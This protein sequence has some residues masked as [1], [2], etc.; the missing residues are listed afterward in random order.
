[1]HGMRLFR[2]AIALAI[3]LA[4]AAGSASGSELVREKFDNVSVSARPG[5]VSGRNPQGKGWTNPAAGWKVDKPVA[6]D[7]PVSFDNTVRRGAISFDLQRKEGNVP[8]D[9]RTVFAL[10][11]AAGNNL[12]LFQVA[13]ASPFNPKFPGFALKGGEIYENGIGLWSPWITLKKEVPPGQWIHVDLTWDDDAKKYGLY[14]DGKAQNARPHLPDAKGGP[15]QADP[16][17]ALNQELAGLK[18]PPMYHDRPFN[19]ILLKGKSLRLGVKT[20][21]EAPGKGTSPLSTAALSEFVVLVNELPKGLSDTPVIA[22]LTDDS[23]KVPGISGKLVAGD[24]VTATLVAEPGGKASF[25]MGKVK[26]IPMAEI[27]ANP[28]GPG[29]PAVDNGTYRGTYTILPGDDYIEGRVVGQFVSSDNVAAVPLASASKWTIDTQP[30]VAYAIDKTDLPADSASKARVSLVVKD[31]NG[32]VLKGRRFKLTLATTDEYTGLVG[33]GNF[34]KDVGATVEARWQGQT[35]AWGTVEFDYKAGFAAKTVILAAKDLESG[36]V[37]VD[38]ITSYKEAS[39]DIALTPPRSLA[40]ARRGLQYIIKI[41]ATRTVLTADGQSRSVIRAT[42]TDPGGKAVAGDN[43]V[44]TLSSPN[45]SIRTIE[46]IT[47][48]SG[49]ATAEYIAGKKIGIVVVTATDILRNV[50]ASVSIVLLA[51]APAKI[52]LKARPE[53]LPADGFSR[54][55]ISVKVTDINDNPND[56]TKVEFRLAKGTGKL[57][58][59]ERVTDRFGE[60]LNRFTAGTVPGIATVLATVRS[61]VPT[62]SEL[63][64]AQNVLFVPYSD[65][66]EEIRVSRWLKKKGDTALKGE[67]VVEYT[68]GRGDTTYTLNA[69]YDCR[70]DFQYVEYW[71]RAQTGDTLAQITPVFIPGS[72]GTLPVSIPA[73]L[74]PRRR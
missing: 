25:D 42:V 20:I 23:F 14:V 27:P 44:F 65:Q 51:D 3:L 15:D 31:A 73:S 19:D 35:D 64:K 7:L 26:G 63:A 18:R 22:S 4:A 38:Y 53:S 50:S 67:P 34:G 9:Y 57:D 52:Y 11:D 32:N 39:I 12:L 61:K 49:V 10:K 29:I 47:N 30:R 37:A 43:V 66:G 58:S 69:P 68:I 46:G 1:M 16:R 55:D 56:N 5:T 48:A 71:D 28:G 17:A 54:S 45:G 60:A 13:W 21:P 8:V 33:A 59:Q 40:A 74:S 72:A 62:L 6:I 36:G 41:E 2:I 70:I 24:K